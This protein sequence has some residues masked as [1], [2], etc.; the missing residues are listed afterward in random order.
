MADTGGAQ[1]MLWTALPTGPPHS[2]RPWSRRPARTGTLV[3]GWGDR[4]HDELSQARGSTSLP[5]QGWPMPSSTSTGKAWR[6][7]SG[8]QAAVLGLLQA[9]PEWLRQSWAP[10]HQCTHRSTNLPHLHVMQRPLNYT[11]VACILLPRTLKTGG[12]SLS[13]LACLPRGDSTALLPRGR[14]AALGCN[15]V[16]HA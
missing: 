2:H 9:E 5:E 15:C 8:R 1:C 12:P 16:P 6:C 11:R 10:A 4:Q 13:P 3:F 14:L 7:N